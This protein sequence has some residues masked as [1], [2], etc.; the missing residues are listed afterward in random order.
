MPDDSFVYTS[1]INTTPERLWRAL[2]EPA[3]TTRYWS[4]AILESDW[5]VG[6]P[7]TFTFRGVTVADPEQV[8]LESDPFRRLAYTWHAVTPEFGRA[9]GYD[10]ETIARVAAEPRSKVSFDIEPVEAGVK[11]TVIHDGFAPGSEVLTSIS[12]GWP[13]VISSLKSLLEQ[14]E[15][16]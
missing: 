16:L 7:V 5:K 1:Y 10:A 6:S 2:T 14:P 13:R 15:G 4:G 9:V 3:F 12:G 8:V 11:L